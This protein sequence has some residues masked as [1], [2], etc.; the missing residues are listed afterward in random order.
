MK[1]E[2]NHPH[3]GDSLVLTGIVHKRSIVGLPLPA[4]YEFQ[5]SDQRFDRYP[6]EVTDVEQITSYEGDQLYYEV[7]TLEKPDGT[8]AKVKYKGRERIAGSP[9]ESFSAQNSQGAN[10]SWTWEKV[11]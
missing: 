9:G 3:E 1:G 7:V 4:G 6:V 8:E 5:N 10:Q 2:A 11:E